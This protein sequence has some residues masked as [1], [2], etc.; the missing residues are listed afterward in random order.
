MPTEI[1]K[2]RHFL[3]GRAL[4]YC[5][6]FCS[7]TG[8][9]LL[10]YDQGVMGSIIGADNVFGRQFGHP[11]SNIQGFLSSSYDLGCVAGSLVAF[12][13]GEKLGRRAMMFFGASIM[14]VGTI[15][16][17]SSFQ[18]SQFFV[19]RVVT[20]FGNGFNSSTIP[21]YQAEMARHFERGRL[22]T[23]QAVVTI[24][25]VVIAYW[26]G[27]GCSYSKTS[28]QWR[29]PISFQG[30]FAIALAI[31][32]FFLPESPRWL[33]Q[34][35]RSQEAAEII[36][37]LEDGDLDTTAEVVVRRRVQIETAIEM[38]SA[39]GPFRFKELFG[40]GDVQNFRRVIISMFLM[41]AQQLNGSNFINYYAP[42]LYTDTIGMSRT[43]ALILSG[44]TE[45]VYLGGS[46]IPIFVVEKFGRRNLLIW[47][48][49]GLSFCFIMVS[50][51]LSIGG[52]GCSIGATVFVF[53]YQIFTG[54]GWLPIPWYMA[55]EI[56]T[57]RLRSRVQAI[58]SAFNWL[59]V[60][61]VVQ[62]TPTAIANISWRI[63][64]VFAVLCASWIPV[65][66]FFIPETSG[67]ELE[68]VDYIFKRKGI[69]R[70][71]FETRGH[72]IQHDTH[73]RAIHLMEDNDEKN[74][75]ADEIED[76]DDAEAV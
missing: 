67:L 55:A 38:E 2:S 30:L 18:R 25:G 60:F 66:Y 75:S 69:T 63:F 64:I 8:F 27:F 54:V 46:F 29:F 39:G 44:C 53:L 74:I 33:I 15:L 31:E 21:V 35:G 20:G 45:I 49:V 12:F 1:F 19:G 40:G 14:V 52:Y 4:R 24:A 48:S 42:V 68:D 47:S 65:V 5:V 23:W 6:V 34:E 37:A 76:I 50:I 22:L 11:D 36:A 32:T 58:A 17:G 9:L 10:G 28:V 3:K 51:F 13:I 61:V 56:N 41:M 7:C 73:A 43:T 72:T 59:W 62:I 57:T 16:L 26:I 71:V 70:G